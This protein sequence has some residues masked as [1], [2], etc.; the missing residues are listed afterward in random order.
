M[1]DAQNVVDIYLSGRLGT[2]FSTLIKNKDAKYK[3][4]FSAGISAEYM[5]TDKFS[6]SVGVDRD[7]F[8]YKSKFLDKTMNLTYLDIPILAKYYVKPWL[9]LEMGPQ[10]SFLLKAKI[11]DTKC[12]DFFKKTDYTIPVGVSFE[13]SFKNSSGSWVFDF[14][15]VI[16]VTQIRKHE[17]YLLMIDGHNRNLRINN[18]RNSAVV[19]TVGYKF[20][21]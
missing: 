21:L 13:P 4:G 12:T 10:L 1:A 17:N 18:S 2:N 20:K 11:G 19:F 14:R 6:L 9:A 5:V 16:G 15:Y 3:C 8:G 7:V